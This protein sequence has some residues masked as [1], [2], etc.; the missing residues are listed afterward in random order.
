MT[1]TKKA[2][3][4]GAGVA[5]LVTARTLKAFGWDVNIYDKESVGGAVYTAIGLTST[6][7]P[8][9]AAY[10]QVSLITPHERDRCLRCHSQNPVSILAAT[11]KIQLHFVR[12]SAF[13]AANI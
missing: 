9:S 6:T 4:I 5:G 1:D 3:V 8:R 7:E 10:G 12:F 11:T 2:C 13:T